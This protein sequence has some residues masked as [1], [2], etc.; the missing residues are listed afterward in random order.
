MV[1][2]VQR[3]ESTDKAPINCEIKL[4]RRPWTSPASLVTRP[5][6]DVTKKRESS[7]RGR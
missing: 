7:T 4:K 5:S 1:K 3:V 2:P 6:S